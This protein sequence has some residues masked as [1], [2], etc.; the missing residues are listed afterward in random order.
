M[1]SMKQSWMLSAAV[2]AVTLLGLASAQAQYRIDTGRVND[3]NN[4][5][6]SSGT[7]GGADGGMNRGNFSGVTA[8]DIVYGNV[9]AGKQFRGRVE[10]TDPLAFRGN[11]TDHPS[12]AFTRGSSGTPYAANSG[13]NSNAQV[14]R[15]FYSD[16]RFAPPPE[17]FIKTSPGGAGYVPSSVPDQRIDGDL[18]LGNVYETPTTVLPQMGQTVLPGQIDPSTN[19]EMLTTMSALYGIRQW[20]AGNNADQQFVARY[21]GVFGNA[22]LNRTGQDDLQIDAMRRE[23]QQAAVSQGARPDL[24]NGQI[25]NPNLANQNQQQSE[26]G[27]VTPSPD[28]NQAQPLPPMLGSP[29]NQALPNGQLQS[30]VPGAP[31][32]GNVTTGEGQQANLLVPAAQQTSANALLEARLEQIYGKKPQNDVDRARDFNKQ[33]QQKAAQEKAGQGAG[34]PAP[35]QGGAPQ[36]APRETTPAPTEQQAVPAPTNAGAAKTAPPKIKSFAE[37]VKAKGLGELLT[38]GEDLMKQ[39]KWFS[40]IEQYDMAQQ[41]APNNML[42]AVGRAN[43]ELG[44]SYYG[45]AE[46]DLRRA[47]TQDPATLEGQYD[48]RAMIGDDRLQFLVNDLKDITNKNPTQ[49]RPVFL[50]AY[51]FYNTGNERMAAGYLD[52]A[53]KRAGAGDTFYGL[54]RK[55]W[56]LP[57]KSDTAAPDL[58]KQ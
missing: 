3:A 31:L 23:L 6:G 24:M 37:G 12:D 1:K 53:E 58:N 50:L 47:F 34:Q 28:A 21:S 49:A 15:P 11:R 35:A 38:K 57:D 19:N 18:R 14:T 56:V 55:H 52:L 46:A 25:A 2:G 51:I 42:I 45:R 39:G 16:A 32:Q 4:R 43:A 48:L 10:S 17:G 26:T 13:F 33:M 30:N 7:N 36:P 40:A 29:Q 22:E 5:I 44:G 20:N 41:V 9:T 27:N 8:N 54:V